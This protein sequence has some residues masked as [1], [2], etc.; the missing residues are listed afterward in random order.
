MWKCPVCDQENTAATV[1]P[2]CG[3]DRTCDYERYPTAF[4][5]T[6]A[7][8]TRTLRRQWQAKQ[9]SLANPQPTAPPS[10]EPAA[11]PA[12][13]KSGLWAVL[14]VVA[15]IAIALVFVLTNQEKPADDAPSQPTEDTALVQFHEG[16]RDYDYCV[17][18]QWGSGALSDNTIKKV[19]E[20]M[21][22]NSCTLLYITES[23]A[24]A[25][26]MA[27]LGKLTGVKELKFANC[28]KVA[29]FDRLSGMSGLSSIE[30]DSV[31]YADLTGVD[32]IGALTSLY[33]LGCG[34]V[35]LQGLTN[36]TQLTFL[37]AHDSHID[38]LTGLES[39]TKLTELYL[40]GNQISDIQPISRLT[41]LETLNLG[42]N[43]ISDLRPLSNLT[44]LD[45][46]T[47]SENQISDLKPISKLTNLTY[48]DLENN[49]ITSLAGLEALTNLMSIRVYGNPLTDTSALEVSGCMGALQTDSKY[50]NN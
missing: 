4:A 45:F 5:V 14:A 8:P 18:I 33:I 50:Y 3:Y 40:R 12:K 30:L 47:L 11:A 26:S 2:T 1:C 39:L 32:D 35:S 6:T 42:E 10:A 28:E 23:V 44:K 34:Q 20:L 49:Q 22:D 27:Q 24:D 16:G 19:Q 7:K 48:L 13:K 31:S 17:E 41:N 38:S 29:D 36:A 46:L 9:G 15:V 25:A 21:D 37:M 43:Q